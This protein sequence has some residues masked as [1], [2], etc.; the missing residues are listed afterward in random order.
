MSDPQNH[1]PIVHLS[2]DYSIKKDSFRISLGTLDKTITCY[3][4]ADE[5]IEVGSSIV[6]EAERY[7]KDPKSY[8]DKKMIQK[9]E[10]LA[11]RHEQQQQ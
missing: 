5:A 3:M 9:M 2:F 10:A 8:T 6:M 11:L 7:K 1:L 4:T